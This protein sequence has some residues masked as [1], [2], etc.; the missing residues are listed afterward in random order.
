MQHYIGAARSRFQAAVYFRHTGPIYI[1]ISIS[2]LDTKIFS[3]FEKYQ[4][5]FFNAQLHSFIVNVKNGY[6]CLQ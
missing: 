3:R 5:V 6:S 2:Q 1:M 4:Y